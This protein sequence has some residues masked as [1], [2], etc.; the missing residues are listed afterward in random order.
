MDMQG[1]A[2]AQS[3]SGF[4]PKPEHWCL[5]L[6]QEKNLLGFFFALGGDK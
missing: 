6:Q 4:V 1:S 5:G 2:Q 3:K